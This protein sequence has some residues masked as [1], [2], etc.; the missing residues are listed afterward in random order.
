MMKI[1]M[2][3]KI[4]MLIVYKKCAGEMRQCASLEAFWRKKYED[5]D[6]IPLAKMLEIID[7]GQRGRNQWGG[8]G[9]EGIVI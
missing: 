6:E 2:K 3:T 8:G 9:K 5:F 7:R 1:R 4:K